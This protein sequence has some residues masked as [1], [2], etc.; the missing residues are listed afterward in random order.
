MLK[1]L[2][3]MCALVLVSVLAHS[4]S[5]QVQG[6]GNY[7]AQDMKGC[8]KLSPALAK[9]YPGWLLR[10]ELNFKVHG[11]A[12]GGDFC[13]Q[14]VMAP[15]GQFLYDAA[16][17]V[18][19][20]NGEVFQTLESPAGS[21]PDPLESCWPKA[22][23]F[24]DVN[25]DDTP[26]FIFMIGC[27]NKR[28]DEPN[29]DNSLY[30]SSE[31]GGQV[32]WKEDIAANKVIAGILDY[33]QVLSALTN[34][35][36][37][38][39]ANKAPNTG[40]PQARQAPRKTQKGAV[41]IEGRLEGCSLGQGLFECRVSGTDGKEYYLNTE[42]GAAFPLTTNTTEQV[43]NTIDTEGWRGKM[44]RIQGEVDAKGDLVKVS[45]VTL[46]KQTQAPK[47]KRIQRAP[48]N[49]S[50]A[51][52]AVQGTV[53]QKSKQPP[54]WGGP[55]GAAQRGAV[56]AVMN[57]GGKA[58]FFMGANVSSFDK[59]NDATDPGFPIPIGPD[60]GPMGWD[61]DFDAVVNWG[62]GKV[63]FFKGGQYIRYDLR[64]DAPDPGYPKPINANT[65][66]GLWPSGVDAAVN[67]GNGKAYFFKGG[68]YVRY[69]LRKDQVDPGY[70]KNI[71]NKTWP[72]LWPSGVDAAVNWSNGKAYFF[73]GR[74]YIRYDIRQ[75]SMDQGYPK[76]INNRTWPGLLH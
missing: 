29:N 22:V 14:T 9:K 45:S 55:A 18:T 30:L 25:G 65:W 11:G 15:E 28:T 13:L 75:D 52:N 50:A 61:S 12:W 7:L 68:Q 26:D 59:A 63:Y 37:G 17:A 21:S 16:F 23:G 34:S 19:T 5:A 1:I 51:N 33:R 35:S 8:A 6:M 39:Q 43:F 20:M 41:I 70:P 54:T 72:G 10:P 74:D 66:P 27:F 48:G 57:W 76:T 71:N 73:K 49:A 38:P 2:R 60:I 32:V 24:D 69:D 58:L 4:A 3:V 62:N 64:N 42:A 46:I 36:S 67:W 47:K 44:I 53:R 56:D 40:G 31:R